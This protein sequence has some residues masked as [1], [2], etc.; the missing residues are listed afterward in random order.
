[1]ATG[2]L[3]LALGTFPY[4][5]KV[6]RTLACIAWLANCLLFIVL[7]SGFVWRMFYAK[8]RLYDAKEPLWYGFAATALCSIATATALVGDRVRCLTSFDPWPC[9]D[10]CRVH[11][12]KLSDYDLIFPSSSRPSSQNIIIS[13]PVICQV[14]PECSYRCIV[15]LSSFLNSFLRLSRPCMKD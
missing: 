11:Y 9:R 2:G 10:I 15:L 1:M 4:A 8:R 6:F 5:T 14:E 13:Q 7:T 3:S 12:F